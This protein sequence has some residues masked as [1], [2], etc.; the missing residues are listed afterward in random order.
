M[1]GDALFVPE[2]KLLKSDAVYIGFDGSKGCHHGK[3][4]PVL[5]TA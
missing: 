3:H 1:A 4:I 2:E 5:A